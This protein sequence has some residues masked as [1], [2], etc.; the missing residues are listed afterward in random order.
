[1]ASGPPPAGPPQPVREQSPPSTS[2][3]WDG[4]KMFNIYIYDYCVKR[5]Y[6]K[7]AQELLQE[8]EIP[9]DSTPPINA[10]QGL[11]FEWWS[12]FWVL[13]TAKN[14]GNGSDDALLYTQ[15]QTQQSNQRQPPRTQPQAPQRYMQPVNGVRPGGPQPSMPNG[16]VPTVPPALQNGAPFTGSGPQVNGVGQPHP[17]GPSVGTPAL[18][19]AQRQGQVQQRPH[20]TSFQSPIATHSPQ[21]PGSQPQP[22]QGPMIPMR[23]TMLPPGH[24]QGP[25]SGAQPLYSISSASGSHPNSPAP[26]VGQSPLL[27]QRQPPTIPGGNRNVPEIRQLHESGVNSDVLRIDAQRLPVLKDELGLGTVD[28][29]SMTM[30]DKSKLLSL[31]K[32]RGWLHPAKPGGP[33]NAAAGPSNRNQPMGPGQQRPPPGTQFAQPGQ[34]QQQRI[35]RNS[36]SPGEENEQLQNDSSPPA[37]K[38]LRT[39]PSGPDQPPPMAGLMPGYPPQQPQP[40]PGGPQHQSGMMTHMPGANGSFASQG[41]MNNQHMNNAMMN[42]VAQMAQY[43][44]SMTNLH[45]NGLPPGMMQANA[46]SPAAAADSPFPGPAD[47][48]QSRPG[49][50]QFVGNRQPQQQNKPMMPPP[51]PSNKPVPKDGEASGS[52]VSVQSSPRNRPAVT[53]GPGPQQMS[54]QPGQGAVGP[55]TP[56]QNHATLTAPSPSAI[57]N[58]S[59]SMGAQGQSGPPNPA[60]NQSQPPPPTS[61]AQSD[62]SFMNSDI[63]FG[64]FDTF[65]DTLFTPDH[66]GQ[67]TDLDFG[68]WFSTDL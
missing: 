20:V 47:G 60:N 67:A 30:E 64:G 2:V 65:N 49:T 23:G 66:M 3:S 45:K 5:G 7:T 36:T 61:N 29:P 17:T 26:H 25:M 27:A 4:D 32:E 22:P 68:E 8:A 37:N 48:P 11:L 6:A 21:H 19:P 18:M 57:L 56:A 12:V 46:P 13:F 54:S 63:I 58:G 59:Q 62:M 16:V 52:A 40:G 41:R 9:H 53:S 28:L 33:P 42:P 44:Q 51:S 34:N 15:H 50:S 35:K 38:R 14:N 43:R 31:A 10:K 39:S 55:L 1:M 24:Q